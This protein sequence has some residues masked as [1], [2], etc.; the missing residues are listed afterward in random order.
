[1]PPDSSP[2]S[3]EFVIWVNGEEYKH[4]AI[5]PEMTLLQYLRRERGLTGTKLGCAE[6]GCGACTVVI[7]RR[8]GDL[9]PLNACLAPLA[10]LHERHVL[11]VEGL[12]EQSG[13][14]ING[15]HRV[16]REM[17]SGSQCGF[18]TPGFV[19]SL[20]A[21]WC[22]GKG[23]VLDIEDIFDGN[24]CRCTGYRP[25]VD[26]A[27]RLFSQEENSASQ[28]ETTGK[29][30]C[31]H[32]ADE[33]SPIQ[34]AVSP[35]AAATASTNSGA[36]NIAN[37][38]PPFPSGLK[39]RLDNGCLA[40]TFT[41]PRVK[42]HRPVSLA[43]V[44]SLMAERPL[45]KLVFGNTEVGIETKF[46]G[47]LYHE[48]VFMGDLSE[49]DYIREER[50]G[51]EEEQDVVEIGAGVS[52][53]QLK[54]YVHKQAKSQPWAAA[55]HEMLRWFA[56]N[57]IRTASSWA[58]NLVTAS[59]ISDLNP[60]W[61]A[62]NAQVLV[63]SREGGDRSVLAVDFVRG[64][65]RVDLRPGEIIRA[66]RIRTRHPFR[67]FIQTY[68]Q[69]KRRDDDIAIVNAALRV[70]LDEHDRVRE[71]S[72]IFGGMGPV[73]RKSSEA[74]AACIGRH[75]GEE[76]LL[77]NTLEVLERE[78]AL[79]PDAIGGMTE[80]RLALVLSFFFKFYL[81]VCHNIGIPLMDTLQS[82]LEMRKDRELR[83][84]QQY[85]PGPEGLAVGHPHMHLSGL[86]HATG[87]AIF[88]DD[89]PL[90][91]GEVYG[92]PVLSTIAHG[93]IRAI[94]MEEAR[95]LPGVMEII[96]Y[97]DVPAMNRQGPVF[98]DEFIFV[99]DRTTSCGQLI[100]LV[101]AQEHGIAQ[102]AAKLVRITYEE[103]PRILTIEVPSCLGGSPSRAYLSP[104][105]DLLINQLTHSLH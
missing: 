22:K 38:M 23:Q 58:G 41:G 24:L 30:D 42:W 26:A 33:N 19:M 39:S 99:E 73:T 56:G 45:A 36:T 47:Q 10:S 66:L 40:V 48:L 43:Q 35:C 74:A 75:W 2:V 82:S 54:E 8:P 29:T 101:I 44:L 51:D 20:Y 63:T 98:H 18:C 102:R 65:R 7:S 61:M 71:C 94:D 103:F 76:D 96:T 37:A 80:Y 1:M 81:Y 59:P 60:L 79:P 70:C 62:L 12:R 49:L 72:F 105:S 28:E 52:L 84:E 34:G 68:K 32:D 55:A 83:G 14:T 78:F 17:Q 5:D 6:G 50:D 104:S 11:T 97:R 9:Q 89:L 46:K 91:R 93:L 21:Q 88:V 100:A 31:A 85:E 95:S 67:E 64:Y 4:A 15:I 13:Q 92:A 69:S 16:Q 53:T 87:E 86:K 77:A 27:R 3:S 57:Q 25:I 90:L